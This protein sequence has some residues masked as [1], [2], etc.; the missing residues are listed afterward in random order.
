MLA[1]VLALMVPL[2]V[3]LVGRVVRV[4]RCVCDRK[5]LANHRPQQTKPTH[6]H[7]NQPTTNTKSKGHLPRGAQG[8]GDGVGGF[9]VGRR[10]R[11]VSFAVRFRFSK[12][13]GMGG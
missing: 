5:H 8:A 1:L 3:C 10:Q 4:C 11:V 12:G 7:H 13:M 6:Q 9:S 2:R